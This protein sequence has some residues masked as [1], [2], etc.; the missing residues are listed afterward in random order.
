MFRADPQG[1]DAVLSDTTM[2]GLAGPDLV[3][4]LLKIEPHLPVVLTTGHSDLV[5]REKAWRLGALEYLAKPFRMDELAA[6]LRRLLGNKRRVRSG[7]E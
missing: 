7:E 3:R 1:F 4:E 6:L 2:P 5:S